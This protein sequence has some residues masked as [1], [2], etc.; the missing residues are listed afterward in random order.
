MAGRRALVIGSQCQQLGELSFLPRLAEELYAVLTDPLLGGCE[1]ALPAQPG[2]LLNPSR[3]ELEQALGDAFAGAR[4]AEASLFLTFL[5]HGEV[6]FPGDGVTGG[7]DFYLLPYDCP[8]P[9][10]PTMGSAWLLGQ[11]LREL[12]RDH[13]TIDGLVVLVDACH[14]GEGALDVTERVARVAAAAGTRFEMATATDDRTAADGCFT[15]GVIELL[16]NGDPAMGSRMA[17]RDIR[18]RIICRGQVPQWLAYDGR[19]LSDDDPAG[20]A[21]L[22]LAPNVAHRPARIP[23]AGTRAADTVEYL[24]AGFEPPALLEGLLVRARRNRCVTVSGPAGSGK[25]TLLA[26]LARPELSVG[27]VPDRFV[28]AVVF[29]DRTVTERSLAYD[30]RDQLMVSVDGYRAAVSTHREAADGW[31]HQPAL[32][33]Q[34][35]GPLGHLT[36]AGPVRL[37]LD[38]LDQLRDD[39]APAIQAWLA[40]LLTDPDGHVHLIVSQRA[41]S[42]EPIMFDGARLTVDAPPPDVLVRYL[43]GRRL[44]RA[45]AKFLADACA[46]GASAWLLA[47]LIAD[48]HTSL[49]ETARDDLLERL[50]PGGDRAGAL[51]LLYD[52]ML[53]EVGAAD[54]NEWAQQLRPVLTPLTAAGAGPVM[55]LTL[56]GAVSAVFGGPSGPARLR[57]VLQRLNRLI[58]RFEPG[59]DRELVGLFHPTLAEHLQH[60][61]RRPV[62]VINGHRILLEQIEKLAPVTGLYMDN[63]LYRWAAEAE[64]EH[65]WQLG[66]ITAALRALQRRPLPTP[67]RNLERWITWGTRVRMRL[68]HDHMDRLWIRHEIAY[69]TGEAGD[70]AEALQLFQELLFDRERVLGPHHPDTLSTRHNVAFQTEELGDRAQALRLYQELLPD[71]ERVLGPHHPGTLSTRMNIASCTG[72]LG[73]SAQALRLFQE[74]LPDQERVLGPHHPDT[75]IT[76]HHMAFQTQKLGDPAQA[77]RLY[78]ELLPDRERVLGP[79]HPDTLTTRNNIASCTGELGDPAQALRLYQELLPDRERVLGPHHPYTLTT[80]INVAVWT[81]KLGDLAQAVRLSQRLLPDLERVLGPHHPYTLTTRNNIAAWTSGGQDP[82]EGE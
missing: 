43:E 1:P 68:E 12:M 18:A 56:L 61:A 71:R 82:E 2:P 70:P 50:N 81:G 75:L 30:L 65:L 47:R 49:D 21:S 40:Q 26:A 78:Q 4:E 15:R 41:N 19:H 48:T 24:T 53:D 16:R 3:A 76:R 51:A 45:L 46:R 17:C 22:W 28:H 62:D 74:L 8:T 11:G 72:E 55:P 66:D 73:D 31:E 10:Q 42:G 7:K 5:G 79:H 32:V 77:L 39:I 6:G 29:L 63:P 14:A 34:V 35:S 38:G 23:L 33:Q 25:S 80:R 69:W 58:V 37:V 44:P 36:G 9:Q 27:R 64:A 54:P 59:T 57:A 67:R 13:D 60:H 20:D 52:R